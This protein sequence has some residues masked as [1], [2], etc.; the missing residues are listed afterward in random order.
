[1]ADKSP[2]LPAKA[3]LDTLIDQRVAEL[4]RRMEDRGWRLATAE[5]CTGG[6]VAKVLTDRAGSS[7]WFECGYVTYS[8]ASKARLLGVSSLT[9]ESYG[10]VSEATVREMAAGACRAAGVDCAVA[11]SGVAGPGGGTP[12]KPVGT[13]WLAWAAADGELVSRCFLWAGD[14]EAVRRQAVA[15][16]LLG[17]LMILDKV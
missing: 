14:R 17:L 6:W 15:E 9:L 13:V 10:A 2:T 16:S 11:I 3:D 12:D 4:A 8:N 7:R 5:S 1:M